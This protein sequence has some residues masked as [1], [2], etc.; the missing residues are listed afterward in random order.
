MDTIMR[1]KYPRNWKQLSRQCRE[2]A[3][4]RC[5]R[6]D[7]AHGVERLTY[8]GGVYPVYLVAAHVH[9]DRENPNPVLICLCPSCH[10]RFYRGKGQL[11]QW[12][13]E[14]LK[15][16]VLLKKRGVL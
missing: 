13:I 16:R 5:E 7:I 12:Y 3:G 15:L 10:F 6:C 1:R 4:W 2:R 8:S 9:H 14:K 11:P